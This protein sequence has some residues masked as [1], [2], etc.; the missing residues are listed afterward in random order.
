MSKDI[1]YLHLKDLIK[2]LQEESE[3][4]N[5]VIRLEKI[6]NSHYRIRFAEEN[7]VY[8]CNRCNV[9]LY[10]N[11]EKKLCEEVILCPECNREMKF[12]KDADCF[13]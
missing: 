6:N 4:T 7:A 9:E 3:T 12:V 13:L 5:D 10:H 8:K 11:I 2:V 1:R